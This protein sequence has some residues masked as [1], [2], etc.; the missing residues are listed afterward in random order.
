MIQFSRHILS[1][2]LTV[3][4]HEDDS[5]PLV[6]FNTVYNVGSKDEEETKTGFAHLFEHLMFSGS[7]NVV[8]F[9]A[10]IQLAGGENN[11][12][13]NADLTNF[14]EILPAEN[15]ETA[16]WLESDRMK[17]L[18]I[19]DHAFEVQRKVVVEEFKETALNQPYS[20]VW[21]LLTDL[22]Y[23]DHPY[24]W[25]TI[26]KDISHIQNASISDV[27]AF[28]NKFYVPS[29]AVVVIA[30]NIKERQALE[31]MNKWF[32]DIPNGTHHN[33]NLKQESAITT[34][35]TKVKH[36]DVPQDAFWLAFPMPNRLHPDYYA[37][38]LLSD[39]LAAGRSSRFYQR[40]YKMNN[41]F[42]SIDAYLTG[43]MDNGLFII[44]CKMME[45][46][47]VEEGKKAVWKE[48]NELKEKSLGEEELQKL[49]NKT[50]SALI[51][52]EVNILNKAMN[53]AYFEVL[54]KAELINEQAEAYK[55]VTT[56]KIQEVA[57]AIFSED[58]VCELNYLKKSPVSTEA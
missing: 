2:G 3:I 12:F 13:T 28:Y 39:A 8:D 30:G 27:K 46:S 17:A 45:G 38:D 29:N 48:L 50:E 19:S 18:K 43:S 14:Y 11:A 16:M 42:S 31:L 44:E 40:L 22:C 53:L 15:I 5:T 54:N 32:A 20:D 33:R 52:S 6:A 10:P 57:L 35:R 24:K 56:Q 7:E 1:N 37:L 4:I 55:L 34:K 25:P 23:K 41:M 58:R 36:A 9:D 21:H 47:S 49:K 26:G 51:Y